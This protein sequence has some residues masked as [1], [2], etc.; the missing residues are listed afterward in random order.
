MIDRRGLFSYL[1]ITFVTTYAIEGALIL[2]G[3]RVTD[4]PPLYGQFVVVGVMWVPALA[5]VLTI[6]FVTHEGFG[7]TNFRIG[8]WRPYVA[9]A[10]VI[11]ATFVVIYALTW[12]LGLGQPDWQLTGFRALMAASGA[13]LSTM[14]LPAVFL[15]TLFFASLV[16]GP[17]INGIFGFGEEFGW[18]GYL[19]PKLMP[20]G[21]TQAYLLVG[22]I[23]GLWHAPLILVGFNYPGY[24]LLGVVWMAALTTAMGIYLNEMTLRYRSSLLAGWMHGA[25]NGQGYGAWRILFTNVN[26]LVGGFTGLVGITMWLGMGVWMVRRRQPR[27]EHASMAEVEDAEIGESE[28]A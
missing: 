21:K 12:L 8:P 17:T 16:I 10:L 11:P 1:A 26:P 7:I 6:K 2:T 25:I 13:D 15:V 24:P 5:T 23:W 3:F 4:I 14:P 22:L 27:S 18:R 19:L 9:T 28:V 20:L